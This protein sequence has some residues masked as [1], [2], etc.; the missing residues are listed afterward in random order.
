MTSFFRFKDNSKTLDNYDSDDEIN[1]AY[2]ATV[3]YDKNGVKRSSRRNTPH[4]CNLGQINLQALS[5]ENLPETMRRDF[6]ASSKVKQ[7]GWFQVY[8]MTCCSQRAKMY[9]ELIKRSHSRI[10]KEMDLRF[11]F[12]HTQEEF[13]A[14]L[15]H[16]AEGAV[17]VEPLVTGIVG[18]E[19]VA[20]A[21]EEL[22]H[23]D[24]HAKILIDP[25]RT[26]HPET[27]RPPSSQSE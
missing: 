15:G 10:N 17:P 20:V 3:R 14:T 5:Q 2:R 21:F 19:G 25:W 1:R 9:V 6:N 13:A 12:G 23:P 27:I 22:A 18:L 11:A 7:R 24:R 26:D 4:S 16:I 8:C